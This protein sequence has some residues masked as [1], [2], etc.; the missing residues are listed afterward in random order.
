VL[1][2]VIRLATEEGEA[3]IVDH[4]LRLLFN[5][6]FHRDCRKIM[7]NTPKLIDV[8]S[9]VTRRKDSPSRQVCVDLLKVLCLEMLDEVSFEFH[10]TLLIDS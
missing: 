7:A 9:S 8:L 4:A 3:V 2:A 1:R 5:A 6:S 10:Q